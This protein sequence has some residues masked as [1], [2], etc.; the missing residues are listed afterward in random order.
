MIELKKPKQC[1]NCQ[2]TFI[3]LKTYKLWFLEKGL[4][5]VVWECPCINTSL[6]TKTENIKCL[7]VNGQAVNPL[8]LKEESD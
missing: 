4:Y 2:K 8:T 7:L 1:A 6:F 3:S 5:G